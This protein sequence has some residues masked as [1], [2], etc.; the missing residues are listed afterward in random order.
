MRATGEFV[1][2]AFDWVAEH[3]VETVVTLGVMTGVAII[4]VAVAPFVAA[5]IGS[6]ASMQ[7]MATGLGALLGVSIFS[8][9]KKG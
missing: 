5:A 6:V 2:S 7:V 9:N 4:G 8:G 3:P 1:H